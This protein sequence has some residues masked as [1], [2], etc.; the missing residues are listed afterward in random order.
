MD[1]EVAST[2]F[3]EKMLRTIA[4]SYA[5]APHVDRYLPQL[6]AV[7]K[8]SVQS[9]RLS[10]LNN[11]IIEWLAAQLG[12]VTPRVRSSELGIVGKRGELVAKLCEHVGAS[13]YISPPGAKEYL[14]EDR[15]EFDTRSISVRLHVYDHPEYRQCFEPFVPY[16]SVL[17]LLL[18]EGEAAPAIL[19]SGRRPP[20]ELGALFVVEQTADAK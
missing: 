18:N 3:V 7:M 2:A 16:A 6:A 11:G 1:T 5:R 8:E 12:V 13:E 17:D 4:Q 19:R 14:T 9:G 10:D 15:A 20:R